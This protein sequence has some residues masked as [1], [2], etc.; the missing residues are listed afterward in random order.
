MQEVIW[1]KSPVCTVVSADANPVSA[2]LLQS[3]S[4]NEV[5]NI[6]SD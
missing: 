5:S 2:Y 1:V 6:G 3:W 4:A